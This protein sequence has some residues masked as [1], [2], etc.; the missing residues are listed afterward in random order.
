L[1]DIAAIS[2]KEVKAAVGFYI[3]KS[4]SVGPFRFNLSKSGVGLSTGVKGFRIGTG[5]RG[6]Y[7]H[8]GR[9]GLYF[10]QTLPSSSNAGRRSVPVEQSSNI[11]FD[12]IE[13]GS[14][15]QM[16]DSSSAELLAEI[17]SKSKKPLIWPWVLGFSVC[18]LAAVVAVNAPLWIYCLLIPLCAGGLIWAVHADKLR[19][20][21]VLFYELE[22]HIEEA[23]QGFHNAFISLRSCSRMW[24]VESKGNITTTYDWKVNAG[25]NA[26]V[27]RKSIA[28]HVGSPPYFQCNVAIPV[29]PAGRQKLYFL[30]DRILV[31]AANGVGAVGFDQFEVNSNEQRFIESDCVPR[32]TRVVDKT[33]RYVNKKGGPD[34][35]FNDNREIPI[36]IYEA[37]LL[38]SRTGLQELFQASRTGLGSSLNFAVPSGLK[39]RRRFQIFLKRPFVLILPT[40]PG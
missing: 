21:V 17:N 24:H 10:R 20:T 7:V 22:P 25:A 19:K 31:W 1:I 13:S 9:G 35:R 15:S 3:R 14:V 16:V 32:D 26:I 39:Q 34:R 12:E 29:L 27:R 5:P 28:P 40:K 30:P 23:F 37:I 18:L 33:W 6:N 36:V 2:M 38:S 4:L 11:N 8:M